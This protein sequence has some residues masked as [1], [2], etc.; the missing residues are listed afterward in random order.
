MITELMI[1]VSAAN[2]IFKSLEGKILSVN[3]DGSKAG[4]HVSYR[5]FADFWNGEELSIKIV[6]KED[7]ETYKRV[8]FN[9][10]FDP[11]ELEIYALFSEMEY[12]KFQEKLN[13]LQ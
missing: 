13:S 12:Q 8:S 11:N 2:R 5:H 9:V 6:G 1:H 7:E 10:P 4:V 3:I